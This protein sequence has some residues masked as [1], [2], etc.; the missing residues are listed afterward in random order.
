[1][2]TAHADDQLKTV[3]RRVRRLNIPIYPPYS[4]EWRLN[5]D[6]EPVWFEV[7]VVQKILIDGLTYIVDGVSCNW[8]PIKLKLRTRSG[9][10]IDQTKDNLFQILDILQEALNQKLIPGSVTG[11]KERH[12]HEAVKYSQHR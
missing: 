10:T 11:L 7:I 6:V 9:R 5:L 3:A 12:I 4:G 2:S 8:W 1:M